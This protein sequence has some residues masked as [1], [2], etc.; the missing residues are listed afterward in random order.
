M[1][2]SLHGKSTCLLRHQQLDV[3][4]AAASVAVSAAATS[5]WMYYVYSFL[6]FVASCTNPLDVLTC[7]VLDLEPK[8]LIAGSKNRCFWDAKS[9]ILGSKIDLGASWGDLWPILASRASQN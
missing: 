2:R 3:S 8:Q 7:R 5:G 1:T 9:M 6:Q 4:V